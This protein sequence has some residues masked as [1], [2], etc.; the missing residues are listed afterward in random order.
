MLKGSGQGAEEWS[1]VW[2][3]GT[4]RGFGRFGGERGWYEM[5]GGWGDRGV[6]MR[7]LKGK[8]ELG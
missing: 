3:L 2:L 8:S 5:K 7:Y 6:L 1:A 4:G